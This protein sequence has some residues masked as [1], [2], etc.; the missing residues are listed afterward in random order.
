VGEPV[1]VLGA[2][3][4]SIRI[5]VTSCMSLD[6]AVGGDVKRNIRC[7]FAKLKA[8]G[9]TCIELISATRSQLEAL[10]SKIGDTFPEQATLDG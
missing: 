8:R 6:S 4:I 2:A 5:C 10:G 7:L 3:I 1:P 9:M